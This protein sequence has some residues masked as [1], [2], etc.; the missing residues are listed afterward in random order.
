MGTESDTAP[1]PEKEVDEQPTVDT[2]NAE[3]TDSSPFDFDEPQ[4]E[5]EEISEG[6]AN[7]G[8]PDEQPAE[9]EEAAPAEEQEAEQPAEE[10][11][12]PAE[13]EQPATVEADAE[14]EE[15]FKTLDLDT[16]IFEPAVVDAFAGVKKLLA[17]QLARE[18]ELEAKLA[19][20]QQEVG[21]KQQEQWFDTFDAEVSA[22]KLPE[23][24]DGNR[25]DLTPSQFK[26]R[27]ELLNEMDVLTRGREAAKLAPLPLPALIDK[28]LGALGK[29][30]APPSK[31][32]PTV[33]RPGRQPGTDNLS[34]EQRAI[35][36]LRS[37]MR[38][39][40][41]EGDESFA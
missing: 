27:T 10:E 38:D 39:F 31:T 41:A 15:L 24:G 36:N 6:S 11:E 23:L 1:A 16:D 22:R 7:E 20:I 25:K 32:K 19:S 5:E 2:T 40:A 33:N 30:P 28:A 8:D 35:R 13:P 9:E 12:A 14:A 17:R 3:P 37:K 18:K 21:N 26:A 29:L 34:P 4:W